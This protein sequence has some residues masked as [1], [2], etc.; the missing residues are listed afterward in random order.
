MVVGS[1]EVHSLSGNRSFAA[2][3]AAR[4]VP[5]G[6]ALLWT[7]PGLAATY[8]VGP[9]QTLANIG[10]VPWES[11]AAGDEV[12]IHWRTDAYH[13]K[14]V[15][16]AR[17]EPDNPIVIRGVPGPNGELPVIDG[18]SAT[19]R[20][21]LDYTNASR[22]VIKIGSANN[23]SDTLPAYIVLEG[24][25]VRS[26]RPPFTFTGPDGTETYSDNAASI[27]VEKAEHLTIRQ[28]LIHDSG[29]GLFIGA[30]D[31]QT[32]NILI[33]GCG[34]YDNGIEGSIYQ[35]N[36]YTAAI[37]ITFQYNFYGPL[38]ADCGGNNLKDRSAGLV[39]RYNW[40]ESGNRQLDLVDAEDSSVLVN[41]PSYSTTFVYGNV[42]IEPD[43]AGNSQMVHYGGDSGTESDY[44][45]G[46]LYFFN[47]T[48]ISTRTGNTTLF[49]LSTNDEHAVCH[50][51]LL[52]VT[53]SGDRLAM[54]SS[55]G[56]LDLS[57]NWHKPNWTDSH[58]GLDGTINDDGTSVS[59]DAPGFE[60][61]GNQDF[62]LADGS[63]CINAGADL[64]AAVLPDHDVAG[65][66][67]SHRA[68][69]PRPLEPPFDIGAFERCVSGNCGSSDP[70]AGIG[71][72]GGMT[73]SSSSGTGGSGQN[74]T[75]DWA[76]ED[77]GCGCAVVG[78]R[79]GGLS[80]V[81]LGLVA[82]A[83]RRRR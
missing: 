55:N 25:D 65:Q 14:F 8:E 18:Q 50:N 61:E 52:Y 75:T 40:L 44:R 29:N 67:V 39:V 13:E 63:P 56:V 32:Q 83:R 24:L 54:L 51:N 27:Y 79:V 42:L 64:P 31:G 34:V 12:L 60:D 69:E 30:F 59:G 15:I 78:S 82:L 49:R 77:S 33:E 28:C 58:S 20:A 7:W 2:K 46:T 47:N 74:G 43:D 76:D 72:G 19:T 62:H 66:Y 6:V 17:G 70:D 23:P 22:G 10:D 9:G 45:K 57:H 35:H 1:Y 53:E 5:F 80:A 36:S 21:E 48:V 4:L 26:G 41:H 3:V 71:G 37:G 11:L 16:C 38:R 68:G 81:L 73:S